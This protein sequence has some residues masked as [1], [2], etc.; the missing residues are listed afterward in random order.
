MVDFKDA[1]SDLKEDE[2]WEV[3]ERAE[4]ASMSR[5]TEYRTDGRLK[6][7]WHLLRHDFGIELCDVPSR[8][9]TSASVI[10]ILSLFASYYL[11]TS[12][13]YK[14]LSKSFPNF[15][16]INGCWKLARNEPNKCIGD[17]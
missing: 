6:D 17:E 13:V 9:P 4:D 5:L 16:E 15:A 1:S 11:L 3:I 7:I 2:Y 8:Y 12:E 14:G 10:G